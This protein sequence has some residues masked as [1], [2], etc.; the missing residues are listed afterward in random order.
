MVAAK[1]YSFSPTDG[2]KECAEI[3][4]KLEVEG[5]LIIVAVECCECGA[6]S[7]NWDVKEYKEVE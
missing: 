2:C 7:S 6:K 4:K 5:M 1:E 3:T